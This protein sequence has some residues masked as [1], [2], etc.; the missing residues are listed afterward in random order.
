MTEVSLYILYIENMEKTRSSHDYPVIEKVLNFRIRV[1]DS[2]REI[3]F[4]R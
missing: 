4:K 2:S 3:V 1:S